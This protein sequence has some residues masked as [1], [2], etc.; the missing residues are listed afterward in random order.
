MASSNNVLRGGLTE[1]HVDVEELV[2][3]V[4]FTG[5]ATPVLRPMPFG[6][7]RKPLSDVGERIP[8]LRNRCRAGPRPRGRAGL[9]RGDPPRAR[10]SDLEVSSAER[11]EEARPRAFALREPRE[12]VPHRGPRH[13][14]PRLG[15]RPAA[16]ASGAAGRASSRSGRADLRGLVSEMTDL[17]VYV[18]TR[19]L[20]RVP[21]G[22]ARDL[23]RGPRVRRG[24]S[25]AIDGENPGRGRPRD[26]RR[27]IPPRLSGTNPDSRAHLERSLAEAS[28]HHGHGK[29]YSLRPQRRQVRA[30]DGRGDESGR[31]RNP[32]RRRRSARVGVRP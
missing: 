27:R 29:P 3:I 21:S 13:D 24:R 15:S 8:A 18:N 14:L 32:R 19:G 17:E 16:L 25:A 10:R 5:G 6:R 11:H 2:N 26:H 23:P 20:P 1:K 7:R 4:R 9:R 28:E 30:T 22:A 31:G 12:R